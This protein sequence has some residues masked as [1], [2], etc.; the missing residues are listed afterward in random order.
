M[1]AAIYSIIYPTVRDKIQPLGDFGEITLPELLKI[2]EMKAV[3]TVAV[4]I[5]V[6]FGILD[7]FGY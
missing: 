4:L 2:G 7:M 5:L 1:G 3:M 6:T